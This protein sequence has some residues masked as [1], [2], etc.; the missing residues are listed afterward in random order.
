MPKH[1]R[2]RSEPAPGAVDTLSRPDRIASQ[3]KA[4]EG[5]VA[6]ILFR[7]LAQKKQ[8]DRLLASYL[9][10]R[11]HLGSRDRRIISGILYSVAR[12]WGWLRP[13]AVPAFLD[14]IAAGRDEPPATAG[15]DWARLFVVAVLVEDLDIPSAVSAGWIRQCSGF[16]A[17]NLPDSPVEKRAAEILRRLGIEPSIADI[18]S[19]VPPWVLPE[20]HCPRPIPELIAWMQRRPPLWLRIQHADTGAVMKDLFVD[21]AAWWSESMAIHTFGEYLDLPRHS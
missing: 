18:R 16:S 14:A 12:W 13:L 10:E 8:A 5:A 21:W 17:E 1:T 9:R 3:A 6:D 19:L 7:T 4:V 11:R 20:I 2:N 15:A